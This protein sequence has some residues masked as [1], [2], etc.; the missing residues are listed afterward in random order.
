MATGVHAM[1][2]EERTMVCTTIIVVDMAR[3]VTVGGVMLLLLRIEEIALL[4]K[5]K[6]SWKIIAQAPHS[7]KCGEAAF[8]AR[9]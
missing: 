3:E 6:R 5:P 2:A 7:H 9:I 4:A 8:F 1:T